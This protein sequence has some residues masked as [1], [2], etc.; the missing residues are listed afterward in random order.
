MRGVPKTPAHYAP[1]AGLSLRA[2][3][4]DW[5]F[6][7]GTPITG[8]PPTSPSSSAAGSFPTAGSRVWF[9]GPAVADLLSKTCHPSSSSRATSAAGERVRRR[10]G[11]PPSGHEAWRPHRPLPLADERGGRI[12]RCGLSPDRAAHDP[13]LCTSCLTRAEHSAPTTPFG[14]EMSG[15]LLY[16]GG[17]KPL[18]VLLGRPVP[19]LDEESVDLGRHERVDEVGRV[20]FRQAVSE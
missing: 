9:S 3:D 14:L 11:T 6:G 20:V 1:L 2:T 17:C 7:S 18:L 5:S 4:M 8:L 13:S 16:E 15:Q 12:I 19:V 10:G